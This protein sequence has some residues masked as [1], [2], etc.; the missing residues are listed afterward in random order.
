MKWKLTSF[1]YRLRT[2]LLTETHLIL[3][4][5]HLLVRGLPE[6]PHLTRPSRLCQWRPRPARIESRE[7]SAEIVLLTKKTQASPRA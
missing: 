4:E 1:Q 2:R 6:V 5:V 3:D 7:T